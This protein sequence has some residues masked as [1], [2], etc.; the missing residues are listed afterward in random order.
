M[1]FENASDLV[2][3]FA[4]DEKSSVAGVFGEEQAAKNRDVIRRDFFM[5]APLAGVVPPS[6]GGIFEGKLVRGAGASVWIEIA[7][8]WCSRYVPAE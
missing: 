2:S 8:Y 3:T 6:A 4:S 7:G 1:C 5:R